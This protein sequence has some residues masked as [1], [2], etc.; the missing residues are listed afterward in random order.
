MRVELKQIHEAVGIT[1]IFVTHD[2]EE[3]LSLSD[4][5]VVMGAGRIEQVGSPRDV[6]ERPASE[7]VARFMGHAN[8]LEGRI[9][10]VGSERIDI[11]LAT[12]EHVRAPGGIGVATGRAAALMARPEGIRLHATRPAGIGGAMLGGVITG[13][14]YQGSVLHVVVRLH[15]KNILRAEVQNAGQPGFE[16]GQE[17]QVTF[18]P[19]ALWV[20]AR[21]PE[22]VGEG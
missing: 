14:T 13:M 17:V 21:K 15:N 16:P 3:A 10:A 20:I 18:A 22:A 12:G 7:H 11:R 5:V 9:E 4:R 8:L 2:R 19:D 6:Y 1:F